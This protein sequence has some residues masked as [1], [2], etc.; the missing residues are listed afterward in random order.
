MVDKKGHIHKNANSESMRFWTRPYV[1]FSPLFH[2][3]IW[4]LEFILA[5]KACWT[6]S[7]CQHICQLVLIISV[8]TT[9]LMWNIC[10]FKDKHICNL[11]SF[12]NV[13]KIEQNRTFNASFKNK[14]WWDFW[15]A[16]WSRF[17]GRKVITSCWKFT[18]HFYSAFFW[19]CILI[20]HL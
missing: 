15:W 11:F 4:F 12:C 17:R 13:M 8:G 9:F 6:S 16:W 1:F 20:Y 14:L 18:N 5:P 7:Q 3:L 19:H 10:T 2:Q